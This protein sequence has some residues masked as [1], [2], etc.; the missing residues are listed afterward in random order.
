MKKGRMET[1]AALCDAA[2]CGNAQLIM[3]SMRGSH[4]DSG[5]Q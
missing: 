3:P 4:R 2:D 1:H 5:G